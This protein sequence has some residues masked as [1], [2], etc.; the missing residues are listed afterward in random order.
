MNTA[1]ETRTT[2]TATYIGRC[3]KGCHGVVRVQARVDVRTFPGAYGR[4][5]VSVVVT[6]PHGETYRCEDSSRVFFVCLCGKH[7]EFRRVV[8]R[9]SEH[10]CGAKCLASTSGVCECSCGGRNHGAGH[11]A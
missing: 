7:V 1:T 10:K 4:R 2:K 5:G 3:R 8:G 11:A 9:V 6:F